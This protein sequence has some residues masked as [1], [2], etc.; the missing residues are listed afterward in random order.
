MANKMR[1][2]RRVIAEIELLSS[3]FGEVRF[4]ADNPTTVTIEKFDLP[5]GFNRRYATVL[6]DLG[7]RYPEYPPQDFYLSTGLRKN[8]KMSSHYFEDGYGEK[9]YCN[10]RLAWYSLHLKKWRPNP[11]SITGGDN[12]LTASEAF[13]KALSTD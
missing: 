6:I 13:Y 11:Y 5:R 2:P 8:G 1:N 9:E 10:S 7:S 4:D 3:H 12:L